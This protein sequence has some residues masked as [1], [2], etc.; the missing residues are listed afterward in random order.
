M[1]LYLSSYLM[2]E[3]PEHL[4]TLIGDDRRRTVVIANAMDDA[5]EDIRQAGVEREVAALGDLGIDAAVLDLRDY[6]D[7]EE[8]LRGDLGGVALTWLRGGNV[9]MLGYAL[10]R[11]G[12]N[13]VFR[14]LLAEDALV[15]AGYSAGPCVLYKTASRS[16]SPARTRRLCK[17]LIRP[18]QADQMQAPNKTDADAHPVAAD[19]G[20]RWV[21]MFSGFIRMRRPSPFDVCGRRPD[22]RST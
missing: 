1:R 11:S 21:M 5:P 12:G 2:G 10:R 13:A 14:G 19:A 18:Q 9:F 6:F 20:A 8:R 3:H 15:Y 16:S 4:A 17:R 7:D 22:W